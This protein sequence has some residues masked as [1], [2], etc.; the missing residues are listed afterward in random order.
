MLKSLIKI[1]IY[2][3]KKVRNQINKKQSKMI[4][5]NIKMI[6]SIN[7]ITYRQIKYQKIKIIMY[8]KMIRVNLFEIYANWKILI[9]ILIYLNKIITNN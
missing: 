8:Q 5:M 6:N 3:R 1:N 2:K 7:K 4:N 9:R